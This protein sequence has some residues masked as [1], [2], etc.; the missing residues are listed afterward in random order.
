MSGKS[1]LKP[2]TIKTAY[3]GT[4]VEAIEDIVKN[5]C[6]DD[7]LEYVIKK[8]DRGVVVWN[9][10]RAQDWGGMSLAVFSEN[11]CKK[12]IERVYDT[13]KLVIVKGRQ[14]SINELIKVFGVNNVLEVAT[15][16]PQRKWQMG[17]DPEVFV[18]DDKGEVLPAWTFLGP[19]I[20]KGTDIGNLHGSQVFADGFQVEFTTKPQLC[21]EF[22]VD[23]VRNGLQKI[24]HCA[25]MVCSEA[26]LTCKNVVTI[27]KGVMDETPDN[28]AQLGCMPS[29]GF[30]GEYKIPM[31]NNPKHI[32]YRFAG[33]HI[34]FGYDFGEAVE[35]VVRAIDSIVG[36]ASVSALWGLEDPIRRKFYG[37]A[38]EHRRPRKNHL[39]SRI[40]SSAVLCHPAVFHL[41]MD[42]IREAAAF[43]YSRFNRYWKGSNHK[44]AKAIN[45]LDVEL[46]RK[47]MNSNKDL[48]MMLLKRIYERTYITKYSILVDLA[49]KALIDGV[50]AFVDPNDMERNWDLCGDDWSSQSMSI[51]R[52]RGYSWGD[53][54]QVEILKQGSK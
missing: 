5:R 38:T 6:F 15:V 35:D 27:P 24:L 33:C 26:K 43:G 32:P 51:S 44:V 50:T 20:N 29:G 46:A 18:V 54:V 22:L 17:T 1:I 7:Y 34:H 41:H 4:V 39:E 52:K 45:E 2:V 53:F 19:Q 21:H 49:W 9:S 37:R 3:P 25:R 23:D 12:I 40:L 16:D 42:L 8:G 31:G 30:N 10:G 14:G 13:N 47:L 28:W 11:T 48:Y 36:V